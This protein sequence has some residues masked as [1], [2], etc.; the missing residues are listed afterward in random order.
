MPGWRCT[1]GFVLLFC[2]SLVSAQKYSCKYT[3]S[4][5]A[6][7]STY[8][9]GSMSGIS[10]GDTIC[11]QAGVY[12]YIRLINIHGTS[13]NPVVIINHG[14]R[15]VLDLQGRTNHGFIIN[16][17]THFV[18]TG[19][20]DPDQDNGFEIFKSP[21][22]RTQTALAIG[23]QV[24]DL[25]IDHFYIHDVEL[26]LH[27]INVPDCNP[28]TWQNNW[29]MKNVFIHDFQIK[30]TTKEGMYIGSSKY[31]SGYNRECDGEMKNILPSYIQNIKVYNNTIENTGWDGMQVSMAN[32]DCEIYQNR[33]INYGGE[34]KNSQRAGIVIGGGSSGMV[35]GNYIKNGKG[36][37]IDVF[38]IGEIKIFNN[39]IIGAE[40]CGIFIGNRKIINNGSF[41]I[42]NNTLIRTG[43]DGIRYNNEYAENN[44]I[45]NNL[46]VGWGLEPISIRRGEATV[47]I[48]KN[49]VESEIRTIKFNEPAK[50][51]FS[52]NQAS[53]AYNGG[54]DVSEFG[55]FTDFQGSNRRVGPKTDIGAFEVDPTRNSIPISFYRPEPIELMEGEEVF[56]TL[57][58]DLFIDYD[59]SHIKLN[60]SSSDTDAVPDWIIFD[61]INGGISFSPGVEDVGLT[62]LKLVGT[63]EKGGTGEIAI[64]VYVKAA[65][66]NSLLLSFNK[67]EKVDGELIRIYPQEIF[68]YFLIETDFYAWMNA[69][70]YILDSEGIKV[71]EI[72]LEDGKKWVDGRDLAPGSYEVCIVSDNK[73]ITKNITKK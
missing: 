53:P 17:S 45:A 59:G 25:E 39:V 22:D 69:S 51:N 43:A 11:I 16:N 20:G 66:E 47:H 26:G 41:E 42:I 58:S 72:K 33:I 34:N 7:K 13:D 71:K 70:A 6:G 68:N 49:L 9:D 55:I 52:I 36:D 54:I 8:L 40:N 38:G 18:L 37:G 4:P 15:V 64:R 2:S 63:D 67:L 19:S 35:H 24:S 27:L 44:L 50:G 62:E 14:G 12:H 48:T 60:L 3:L 31:L 32:V 56:F 29:V 1:F 30:N 57:P 5:N 10:P 21:E 73:L 28:K 23:F 65:S 46:I 61:S